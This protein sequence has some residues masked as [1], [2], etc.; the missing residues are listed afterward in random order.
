[1][2]AIYLAVLVVDIG[3]VAAGF[4]SIVTPTSRIVAS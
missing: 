1:V 2:S 4:M 3:E